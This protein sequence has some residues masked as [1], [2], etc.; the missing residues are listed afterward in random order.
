[1]NLELVTTKAL[2]DELESRFKD[3]VFTGITDFDKESDRC[4]T[5]YSGNYIMGMGLCAKLMQQINAVQE[6]DITR[7]S[8]EDM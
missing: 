5:R 4:I 8:D 2:L 3:F 6:R 7:L 1:M